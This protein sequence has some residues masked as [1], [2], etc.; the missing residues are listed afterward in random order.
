MAFDNT[1]NKAESQL[2]GL[3]KK[4]RTELKSYALAR[5]YANLNKEI[6]AV[7]VRE[8][9]EA[10]IDST[11]NIIEEN[12]DLRGYAQE[13]FLLSNCTLNTG[14]YTFVL[15]HAAVN[16]QDDSSLFYDG[17]ATDY[18]TDYNIAGTAL[19]FSLDA[20]IT[21]TA[22]IEFTVKYRYFI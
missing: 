18:G 14:V 21:V 3:S 4:T 22:D 9:L 15:D 1:M 10:I 12:L 6:T 7:M 19:T 17:L 13:K 8:S 16:P 2:I 5:I 11:I 20:D